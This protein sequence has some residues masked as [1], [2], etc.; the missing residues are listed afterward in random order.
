MTMPAFE[1][2]FEKTVEH[3]G[4]NCPECKS[5]DFEW[6]CGDGVEWEQ[7]QCEDCK[8]IWQNDIE[9]VRGPLAYILKKEN[10]ILDMGKE[11]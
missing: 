9:I 5:K 4:W 3:N 10:V 11:E 1:K 7:W 2:D 8:I 6:I